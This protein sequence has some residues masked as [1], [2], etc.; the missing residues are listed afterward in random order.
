MK[1]F[2]AIP[3]FND[4]KHIRSAIKSLREQNYKGDFDI[5]VFNDGSSPAETEVLNSIQG[6]KVFH[7]EKNLGLIKTLNKSL[8]FA[9]DNNY[10]IYFRLDSDDKSTPSRIKHTLYAMSRSNIDVFSSNRT[11]SDG[12]TTHFPNTDRDVKRALMEYN[13]ITH[14]SVAFNLRT[15]SRKDLVYDEKY[16]HAEDYALWRKLAS[17]GYRFYNSPE[18]LIEYFINPTGITAIHREEQDK[19]VRKAIRDIHLNI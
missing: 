1:I 16:I 12:L 3:Y 7:N 18:S 8:N 15:I 14:S 2:I 5:A 6:V 11:Q 4:S 19:S 9:F 10:D 17:L 13:P